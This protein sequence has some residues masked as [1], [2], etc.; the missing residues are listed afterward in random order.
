MDI[1]TDEGCLKSDPPDELLQK[2]CWFCCV[3][4]LSC[5][6]L[7]SVHH[8]GAPAMSVNIRTGPRA[9][10]RRWSGLMASLS[11][12]RKELRNVLK[13]KTSLRC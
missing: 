6:M 4:L 8:R 3:R 13:N 7:T 10:R 5:I 2:F 9:G 11:R 1:L 12:K